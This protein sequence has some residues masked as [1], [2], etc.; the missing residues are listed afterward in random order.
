MPIESPL[1]Q[2]PAKTDDMDVST[3]LISASRPSIDQLFE[4]NCFRCHGS[5]KAI[6]LKL[7]VYNPKYF[8]AYRSHLGATALGRL[9][10][11]E[12]PPDAI[13]NLEDRATMLKYLSE[14]P[15]D[16]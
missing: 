16:H 13:L 15:A 5:G 8:K 3:R 11:N 4:V 14:M 1:A 9:S 7:P 10:S 6:D 12:M 2:L